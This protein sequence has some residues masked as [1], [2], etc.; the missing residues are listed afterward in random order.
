[1]PRSAILRGREPPRG[2]TVLRARAKQGPGSRDTQG[3]AIGV[4]PHALDMVPT[5]TETTRA[6]L[7]QASEAPTCA[8]HA[9]LQPAGTCGVTRGATFAR[10]WRP[11]SV[12]VGWRTHRRATPLSRRL[13]GVALLRHRPDPHKK[14]TR[15]FRDNGASAHPLGGCDRGARW[16]G[17]SM[18]PPHIAPCGR[19]WFR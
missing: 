6:N 10:A 1:M 18:Y 9:A 3:F 2:R 12:S 7:H 13:R 14:L 5:A 4:V 17:V 19:S 8:Q 16:S 15:Q 11:R